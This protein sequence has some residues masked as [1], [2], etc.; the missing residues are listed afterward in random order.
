MDMKALIESKDANALRET[1]RKE[2]ALANAGVSLNGDGNGNAHPLH[3]ICDAVF[4]K[5][6]MDEDAVEVA[7]IF[8]EFGANIDGDLLK[9]ESQ[10]PLIAAASLH[11]EK[12]G[13]FYIDSG[14]NIYCVNTAFDGETALHWAA[15]CGRDKL[16]ERLIRA[17]AHINLA[18][19]SYNGTPLAWALH[20]L[21]EGN[22]FNKHN[23]LKC[24]KLLLQAG[25][26][27]KMLDKSSTD[28]LYSLAGDD[29]ELKALLF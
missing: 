20:M 2:P 28:Y 10:T 25:A 12:L 22:S 6:I 13:I 15:Y 19:A 8:L 17:K 21:K 1:L 27:I 5:K 18:D 24:I 9:G 16:T 7:K 26:D 29:I 11:A 14:A 4:A 23:Q 3:R